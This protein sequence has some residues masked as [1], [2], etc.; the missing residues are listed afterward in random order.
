MRIEKQQEINKIDNDISSTSHNSDESKVNILIEFYSATQTSSLPENQ[1]NKHQTDNPEKLKVYFKTN[2]LGTSYAGVPVNLTEEELPP[3]Y[4]PME[5]SRPSP[6]VLPSYLDV[7]RTPIKPVKEIESLS[8]ED[9][10]LLRTLVFFEKKDV[11][12]EFE[13]EDVCNEN[14]R[15]N[16][17]YLS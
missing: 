9:F 8:K 5:L 12:N 13:K 15:D 11:C 10:C 6:S 14:K 3:L 2:N 1:N 4:P 16:P 17:T 7:S